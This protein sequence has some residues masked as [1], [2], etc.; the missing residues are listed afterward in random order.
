MLYLNTYGPYKEKNITERTVNH[1][2]NKYLIKLK[3]PCFSVKER[4][5]FSNMI[6]RYIWA[7]KMKDKET[8][9]NNL[10]VFIDETAVIFF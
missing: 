8:E 5:T 3:F 2:L 1:I 6:L 4:S 7:R 10:F 9:Q